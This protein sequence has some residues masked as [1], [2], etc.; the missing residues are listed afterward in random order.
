MADIVAEQL[1]RV[2][3]QSTSRSL[4]CGARNVRNY[5]IHPLSAVFSLEMHVLEF[6]GC[7][8]YRFDACFTL[9]CRKVQLHYEHSVLEV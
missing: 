8:G 4:H 2:A 7:G 3:K 5:R 6:G 1:S 9:M